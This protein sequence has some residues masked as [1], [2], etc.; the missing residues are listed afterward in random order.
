MIAGFVQNRHSREALKLFSELHRSGLVPSHSGF[1]SSLFACANSGDIEMGKQIHSLAIKR[2]F[3]FNP[4]VGNGLICMYAKCRNI[5]D[6][7][8][9]SGTMIARDNVPWNSL[10]YRLSENCL[11]D[12]ARKAFEN[13]PERDVV[14]WTAI[15]SAYEQA[16][17][18]DI[19]FELFG[20][21]LAGGVKP[22]QS[23]ISSLLGACGCMGATKLGEQIR[24]LTHKVG[25][26]ACLFVSN[27]LISMYFKCGSLDGFQIIQE[28]SYRDIV[29]WNA[30]LAGC[31]Q[32]GLGVEA[33]EIFRQ[34]QAAGILPNEISF[35][36][37]LCGCSHSGL[38][39]KGWEYFHS[40]HQ[41]Y[42]IMPL[43]HHY[44]CMVSLLG[45]AGRLS[46]LKS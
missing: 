14:S 20:K 6:I 42:G 9:V 27:A 41:D 21:M 1:T 19:A 22:N 44:S 46:E 40:M 2:R 8:R 32:N 36:G 12:D 29:S 25:L 30:V 11:L 38:M 35:L 45:R 18:G 26:N 34:M 17:H 4:F 10:D 37:V 5:Q 28:M 3:H 15:I 39:D 7:S 13:M 33:V 31:G 24:A 43:V 23:T 16:G